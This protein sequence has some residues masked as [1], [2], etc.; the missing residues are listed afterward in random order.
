MQVGLFAL[1]HHVRGRVNKLRFTHSPR[2]RKYWLISSLSL[3]ITDQDQASSSDPKEDV[4]KAM[5]PSRRR[6]R[7]RTRED[8]GI[9]V[10]NSPRMPERSDTMALTDQQAIVIGGL[11]TQS[12]RLVTLGNLVQQGTDSQARLEQTASTSVGSIHT[13][14]TKIDSMQ[15]QQGQ[16]LM[17]HEQTL[18]NHQHA[19]GQMKSMDGEL[20]FSKK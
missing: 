15:Q 17:P 9:S 2:A 19:Q 14:L 6:S 18:A 8:E 20:L 7:T 11:Q 13:V 12:R 5:L 4:D 1:T 16:A 3:A 10:A